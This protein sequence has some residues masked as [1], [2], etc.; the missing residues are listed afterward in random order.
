MLSALERMQV[1]KD[2]YGL[3]ELRVYVT[4][5]LLWLGAVFLWFAAS[6]LCGRRDRF[7]AV[8]ILSA[9]LMLLALNVLNPD[10]LIAR[11]NVAR[12]AEG[13]SFDA[14]HALTLGPE[15]VPELIDGLDGLPDSDACTVARG[16]LDRWLGETVDP[17]GWNL[18]R[19][20]AISAVKDNEDR[21]R[22]ACVS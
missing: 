2:A 18:G 22:A 3:T 5:I 7:A 15:A 11:T 19:S 20:Q 8:A 10:A 17:R 12:A 21:L 1:Y 6:V 13:K 4:A 16:L 9:T 14:H